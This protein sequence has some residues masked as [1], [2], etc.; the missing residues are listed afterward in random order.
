MIRNLIIIAVASFL[1]AVVCFAGAAAVG[2][3]DLMEHGWH[4]S[5]AMLEALDEDSDVSVRVGGHEL[6]GP[7]VTRDLA[8]SGGSLLQVDVPAEVSFTQGPVASMTITGPKGLVDR[9]MLEDG[10]LRF[11]DSE[12][13][14]GVSLR[15]TRERLKVTVVAPDVN[16]FVLNGSPSLSIA[17][18]DQP[19][20]TISVN[21]SGEVTGTGKTQSLSLSIAG[22][23][24]ASLGDLPAQDAS[25]DVAGSGEAE[26]S[27]KGAVQVAIAGSGDVTLTA[28]PASLSSNIN[29]S[30]DLHLPE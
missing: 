8:W 15:F 7:D 28:K 4:I 26:L 24:E 27:A 21:G 29:G 13:V 14:G 23:G 18:Y 2:G 3:R 25:V 1:L 6:A 22:S 20:L 10:R 17:A 12:T 9:V 16:R 5:P 30:G 19:D 11:R